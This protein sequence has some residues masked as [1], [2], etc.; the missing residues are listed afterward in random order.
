M[1]MTRDGIAQLIPHSGDMALLDGVLRWDSDSIACVSGRHRD[2]ANPLVTDGVL[3]ALCAIEFAAQAMALH[4]GLS[5]TRGPRPK[6]GY[7]ASLR[8][9]ACTRSRIDDLPDQLDI[10]AEKMMGDELRVTYRFEVG[11]GAL[12]FLTGRATVILDVEALA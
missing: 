8:Q 11:A 10:S 5:Y 7:L 2:P 1:L 3:P 12:V 4:G 9:V 6:A